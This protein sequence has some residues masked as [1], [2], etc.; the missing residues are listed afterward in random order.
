LDVRQIETFLLKKLEKF[1][2][3]LQVIT[4]TASIIELVKDGCLNAFFI[5][6]QKAN[7]FSVSN[8]QE[9]THW[10]DEMQALITMLRAIRYG[11][12]IDCNEFPSPKCLVKRSFDAVLGDLC[13]DISDRG[14]IKGNEMFN[15]LSC[16]QLEI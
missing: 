16:C 11:D 3:D 12:V 5:L 8:R 14:N 9:I 2:L 1:D 15:T 13:S 6:Q 7:N 10:I 4:N